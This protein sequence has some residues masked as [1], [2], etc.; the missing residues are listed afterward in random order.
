[1]EISA[2]GGNTWTT[3]SLTDPLSDYTWVFWSAQWNP[4]ATGNYQIMVRATDGTGTVQTAT[5]SGPFPDGATG[6][7]VIDISVLP[8]ST[9]AQSTT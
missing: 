8:P 2:D 5:V 7:H 3:A 6:Y 9:T 4:P 1:M